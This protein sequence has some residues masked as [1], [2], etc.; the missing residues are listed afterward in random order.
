MV[1]LSVLLATL[2]PWSWGCREG[3]TRQAFVDDVLSVI[4]EIRSHPDVAER[5]REALVDYHRSAFRDLDSAAA[6]A[7][8]LRRASEN[9]ERGVSRLADLE[10]PDREAAEIV[11]KLREG[12]ETVNEGN[13]MARRMLEEAAE[14]DPEERAGV[15]ME[16]G[17]VLQTYLEGMELLIEGMESLLEYAGN[18]GL[19]GE[20]EISLR[21]EEFRREKE[22]LEES[23]SLLRG[24]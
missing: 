15:F 6:A 23:L 7:D 14:Q 5:G 13:D 16:S 9:N 12:L 22:A 24:E 18:N 10:R 2:L 11:D 17:P 3:G 8:A 20:E 1:L 21:I 4:R 19:R